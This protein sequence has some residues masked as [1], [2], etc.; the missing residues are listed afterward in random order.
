M[1]NKVVYH[2]MKAF[3]PSAFLSCGSIFAVPASARANT[4]PATASRMTS[5]PPSTGWSRTLRARSSSPE[6]L[7]SQVGL[8]ACCGDAR[9]KG[10]IGLGLPVR[11]GRS[12]LQLRLPAEVHG[13]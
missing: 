5:A 6:F 2:T 9:V 12:Q 1:H 8:R 13:S 4:T 3:R 10:L 11:G 7:G